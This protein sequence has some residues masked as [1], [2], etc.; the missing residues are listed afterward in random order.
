MMLGVAPLI[1]HD[2]YSLDGS[3]RYWGIELWGFFSDIAHILL[4]S[5]LYLVH[6]QPVNPGLDLIKCFLAPK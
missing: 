4:P 2:A 5:T 6:T 1:S 3:Q